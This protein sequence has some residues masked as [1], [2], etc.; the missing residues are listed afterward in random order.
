MNKWDKYEIIW[1]D[2]YHTSG[3]HPLD[4]VDIDNNED[5]VE[6]MTVGYFVGESKRTY[7]FAQ[8][9]KA[10]PNLH[11]QPDTYV[12]AVLTIPK[13]AILKL[14]KLKNM[15]P[16]DSKPTWG[17]SKVWNGTKLKGEE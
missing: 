13:K 16:S 2:S 1:E 14:A 17:K 3:W 4:F 8:S 12:D 15:Q 5:S 9:A 6:Q 11:N 10:N 7:S